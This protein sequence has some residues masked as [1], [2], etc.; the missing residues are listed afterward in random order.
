MASVHLLK[1]DLFGGIYGPVSLVS[2]GLRLNHDLLGG[3]HGPVSLV[4]DGIRLKHA[5]FG[6]NYGFVS[7]VSDGLRLRHDLF[8]GNYGPV[9]LVSDGIRLKHGLFGGDYGPA[10]CFFG[11]SFDTRTRT[12]LEDSWNCFGFCGTFEQF[13]T[14]FEL[15]GT[16]SKFY[17]P[18]T[19]LL[20]SNQVDSVMPGATCKEST[21]NL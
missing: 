19:S 21:L 4:S 11:Q 2:D 8:G 15:S 20:R 3:I 1:H 6:G 9:S 12:E 7:L 16:V 13:P 10:A 17:H 5:L 14:A 18:V